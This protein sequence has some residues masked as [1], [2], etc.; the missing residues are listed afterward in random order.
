M[1][2]ILFTA[3]FTILWLCSSAQYS[4]N[5]FTSDFKFYDGKKPTCYTPTVNNLNGHL[6]GINRELCRLDSLINAIPLDSL[7]LAFLQEQID[8]C[9]ALLSME[10]DVVS[11]DS[12]ISIDRNGNEFDL[13]YQW[14]FNGDTACV[15]S[16]E[17]DSIL[18]YLINFYC[19]EPPVDTCCGGA[20]FAST[21]QVVEGLGIFELDAQFP[22]TNCLS[23]IEHL[24]TF[25]GDTI[26]DTLFNGLYVE[27]GSWGVGDTL[28]STTCIYVA[29]KLNIPC[30]TICNTDT[31]I[32][33]SGN[34]PT[35]AIDVNAV[36]DRNRCDTIDVVTTSVVPCGLDS[37]YVISSTS[38][39]SSATIVNDSIRICRSNFAFE[40]DTVVYVIIS[41]C[42]VPN[43]DTGLVIINSPT[44]PLL[45]G[46]FCYDGLSGTPDT[47]QV[48]YSF[49]IPSGYTLRSNS[50]MFRAIDDV[51]ADTAYGYG[52]GG[53]AKLPYITSTADL[54]SASIRVYVVLEN[55][56]TGLPIFYE[57]DLDLLS[58][59]A[60]DT[61]S[62]IDTSGTVSYFYAD[63]L[64]V[65][66]QFLGYQSGGTDLD[67]ISGQLYRF[68]VGTTGFSSAIGLDSI[69]F[70]VDEVGL[71]CSNDSLYMYNI[72]NVPPYTLT[73][74]DGNVVSVTTGVSVTFNPSTINVNAGSAIS[75]LSSIGLCNVN[76][77]TTS[78][79]FTWK[80]RQNTFI[81]S[82]DGVNFSGQCLNLQGILLP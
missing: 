52:V 62:N 75:L 37:I 10:M 78:W 58:D 77:Y 24:V 25:D 50:L 34:P 61:L 46:T 5:G 82:Y 38:G 67:I 19:P 4:F 63:S 76:E 57:F 9:F 18:Q 47:A 14:A 22:D 48:T 30:D 79:A 1:M 12:T 71:P 53:T 44:T 11:T 40:T 55:N 72:N 31:I 39:I 23:R 59:G 43:I 74:L 2:R 28:F 16:T 66:F 32:V 65:C 29:T 3:I 45:A 8:S 15:G 70:M 68:A 17:L 35:V 81:F 54:D 13:S 69:Y 49:T 6:M 20:V 7:S 21:Y 26:I 64:N 27:T 80:A 33:L 60:C 51:A 73:E 42:G 56:T 41:N 36:I